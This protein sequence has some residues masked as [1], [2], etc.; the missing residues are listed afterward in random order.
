MGVPYSGSSS[1]CGDPQI[2]ASVCVIRRW[3]AVQA[4]TA[5][6]LG[7]QVAVTT[8]R[9]DLSEPSY[10]VR[11]TKQPVRLDA[12][13]SEPV[14]QAVDSIVDFRQR[15][16]VEGAPA[17]ERTVVK[18]I[19]DGDRLYVAVRA[20]DTEMRGVRSTQLRRDADLSSDDNIRLA[21]DNCW[22]PR[23]DQRCRSS[24]CG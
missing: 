6:S 9:P 24:T 14:W 18:V 19:R 15:E 22:R 8:P 21:G 3:L 2:S 1:R 17:T 12:R 16:P 10:L 7:A 13:F 4:L 20:Y 5:V 23:L 11:A